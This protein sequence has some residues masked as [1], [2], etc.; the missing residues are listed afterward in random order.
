MASGYKR[1]SVPELKYIPK[2]RDIERAGKMKSK[3]YSTLVRLPLQKSLVDVA[4]QYIQH[5]R[6]GFDLTMSDIADYLKVNYDT[7]QKT[8]APH[9]KH[10]VIN[11]KGRFALFKYE[12]DSEYRHLFT[13]RKLFLRED[14]NRYILENAEIVHKMERYDWS[15]FSEL[16]QEKVK[17]LAKDHDEALHI[18]RKLANDAP[19]IYQP[20]TEKV[21]PLQEVPD[22][23]LGIHDLI[24]RYSANKRIVYKRIQQHAIPRIRIG[25]FIRY[26]KS[27]LKERN[28]PPIFV[29]PAEIKKQPIIKYIEQRVLQGEF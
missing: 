23:L 24:G 20:Y 6:Q 9:I 29:R 15:D 22:E 12:S 19:L 14:F 18:M 11:Q 25:S 2:N 16:V 5:I 1:C 27:D 7:A 17:L 3:E 4:D 8:I 10:I 13:K 26:R 21:E 28:L